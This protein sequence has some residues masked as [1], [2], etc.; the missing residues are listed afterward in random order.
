MQ[1]SGRQFYS[2]EQVRE[3]DRR[4]IA[5]GIAGRELMRRA[6]AAAWRELLWRWPRAAR[7]A[8][9]CGPGNNG[10]DGYELAR[11]A[12]RAGREVALWRVGT[13]ARHGDAV[14]ARA[15]WRDEGGAEREY[16][17]AALEADVVVD[18]IFGIGLTRAPEDAARAAILAIDAARARGAGVVALDVP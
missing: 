14:A 4:A 10:G 17:G 16:A 1:E 3:L 11:L 6:A 8:V 13:P 15:A 9:L 12:R 2:A 18:A 5:G 7:I